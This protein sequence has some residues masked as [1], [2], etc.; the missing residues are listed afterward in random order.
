LAQGRPAPADAPVSNGAST[1]DQPRLCP[2]CRL[3]RL[4][5]LGRLLSARK[6]IPP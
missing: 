3:G 6:K 2:V 1:A 5:W 4:V